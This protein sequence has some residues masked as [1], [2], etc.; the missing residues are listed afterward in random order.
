MVCLLLVCLFVCLLA[1]LLI[2]VFTCVFACLFVRFFFRLS[3]LFCGSYMFMIPSSLFVVVVDVFDIFWIFSFVLIR[4]VLVLV[5]VF[6]CL[7]SLRCVFGF[8]LTLHIC[9]PCFSY[10]FSSGAHHFFFQARGFICTDLE[11]WRSISDR[12]R[13]DSHD[14]FSSGMMMHHHD[15]CAMLMNESWWCMH[16][17]DGCVM[18]VDA[19][20]WWMHPDDRC[21]IVGDAPCWWIHHGEACIMT[22]DAS[23]WWMH[24]DASW[25]W[26]H[27]VDGCIIIVNG[28]TRIMD[29]S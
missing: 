18:M 6:S 1:C 5:F 14:D 27:H 8:I 2:C 23:W 4:L 20:W 10:F 28:C 16:H 11:L 17:D 19:S 29:A 25:W 7:F 24:L 26:M 15:G 21:I 12:F 13:A 9:F 22:M 3:V